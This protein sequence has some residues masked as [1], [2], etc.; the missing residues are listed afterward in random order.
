MPRVNHVERAPDASAPQRI[1]SQTSLFGGPLSVLTL[2]SSSWP[3]GARWGVARRATRG[4]LG[5]YA[6]L[7]MSC[8]PKTE[9]PSAQVGQA[10]DALELKT[11]KLPPGIVL[12]RVC[13]PSGPELCFNAIDDNCNGIIDEGC[14]MPTGLVQFAIA[15]EDADVD[16]DL[17]VREPGGELVEVG[18]KSQGGLVKE[19]DCPGRRGECLNQN[20]E[21][22]YL[23]EGEPERG[24]YRVSVRLEKW[25]LAQ[26]PVEVSLGAR[27]GPKTFATRM[28]LHAEGESQEFSFEL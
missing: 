18:R 15:W 11:I 10:A 24:V 3:A 1:S 12:E 14:G 16:V 25:G 5:L 28:K 23:S 20:V 27:V 17:L 21:N 6:L 2:R 22:V 26:A 4:L 9:S 7:L 8:A 13:V 19:R